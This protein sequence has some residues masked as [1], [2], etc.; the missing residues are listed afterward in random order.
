MKTRMIIG[1][2]VVGLL[3]LLTSSASANVIFYEDFEGPTTEPAGTDGRTE[4]TNPPTI[5]N[6]WFFNSPISSPETTPYSK[7][8]QWTN[9]EQEPLN[10]SDN[11]FHMERGGQGGS[12]DTYADAV[13]SASDQTAMAAA[14][15]V[16][17][18]FLMRN[19]DG[20][21]GMARVTAFDGPSENR[22]LADTGVHIEFPNTVILANTHLGQINTGIEWN[23]AIPIGVGRPD[24]KLYT[25]LADFSTDTYSLEQTD[26]VSTQSYTD[27]HFEDDVD[28]EKFSRVRFQ[29]LNR[30]HR[31]KIDDVRITNIPEPSSLLITGIGGL[32]LLIYRSR[33]GR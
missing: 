31:F 16:K 14:G 7:R 9:P 33:R 6:A 30:S 8:Y 18:E 32:V 24:W 5:G 15:L 13:F 2:T 21:Q 19:E 23:G 10:M 27:L 20:G 26:G 22:D 17:I 3:M 4:P 1:L 11:M 12:L 25:I 29:V 28:M